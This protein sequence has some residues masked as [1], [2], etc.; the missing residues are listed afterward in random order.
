MLN[1]FTSE[2]NN[3]IE[4]GVQEAARLVALETRSKSWWRSKWLISLE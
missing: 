1:L 3:E 2:S 4:F